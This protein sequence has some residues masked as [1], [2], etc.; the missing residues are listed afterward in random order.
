VLH[1][2]RLAQDLK[3]MTPELRQLIQEENAMVSQ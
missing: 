2:D 1:L 3:D